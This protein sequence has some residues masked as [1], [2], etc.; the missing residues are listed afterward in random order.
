MVRVYN[1]L[2][3]KGLASKLILQV[4]DELIVDTKRDEID[5]VKEII[6]SEMENAAELAVPLTV[7]IN[8]GENWYESK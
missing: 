1:E 8:I 3:K 5:V 6:K 4:H 7:D 2:D